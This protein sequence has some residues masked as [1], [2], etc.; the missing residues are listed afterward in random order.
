[1]S[2]RVF[3]LLEREELIAL[4]NEHMTRDF[5]KAELKPLAGILGLLDRNQYLPYGLFQDED[6]LSYALFWQTGADDH[7]MMLDYFA[8]LPE[9][10]NLGTG[11]TLLHEML[12]TFCSDGRGIFGEVEIP[13]TGDD[14][15]D[16]LRRRRLG[17]YHRAGLREMDFHTKVW[18]VPYIVLAYGPEISSQA[19]METTRKLYHNVFSDAIYQRE[20]FIPWRKA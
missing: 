3:R 15:V 17:F 20:V 8:V 2:N 18:G 11:G 13:D 12:E 9:G 6:L 4:Y 7:Y 19:L 5:P 10:R 1:M 16:A 14:E